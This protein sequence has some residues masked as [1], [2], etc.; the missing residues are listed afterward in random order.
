MRTDPFDWSN[1]LGLAKQL[2]QNKDD[3]ASLRSAISRAY[4]FVYNLALERAEKNG[5]TIRRDD[6]YHA[7][8]W[9]NYA[10]SPDPTCVRLGEIA[11]RLKFS[12]VKA[13][14]NPVFPRINEEVDASISD[15]DDFASKMAAL[16][17]RFPNPASVRFQMRRD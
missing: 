14:Y 5:F 2:A 1:Y 16:N 11:K 17:L 4:Y 10:G 6:S 13:D 7:Q 3:E 12:R 15:A 8:L 9:L